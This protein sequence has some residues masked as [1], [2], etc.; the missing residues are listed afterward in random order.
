MYATRVWNSTHAPLFTMMS[1]PAANVDS[2]CDTNAFIC[3]TCVSSAFTR[4]ERSHSYLLTLRDI[5]LED[6][7]GRS[8]D[9]GFDLGLGLQ[10][11]GGCAAK[12]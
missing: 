12:H 1:T 7:H 4:Q 3:A 8:G 5:D 2:A 10:S 11:Q 9:G 6:G